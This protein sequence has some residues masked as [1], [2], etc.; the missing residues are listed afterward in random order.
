MEKKSEVNDEK[1]CPPDEAIWFDASSNPGSQKI[2]EE[3]TNDQTVKRPFLKKRSKTEGKDSRDE[4]VKNSESQEPASRHLKNPPR[5]KRQ[6]KRCPRSEL[7]NFEFEFHPKNRRPSEARKKP[8][9]RIPDEPLD[10]G[11][12]LSKDWMEV[13]YNFIHDDPDDDDF[14]SSAD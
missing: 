11:T 6:F 14:C 1:R 12:L 4:I 9:F 8:E 7:N 5:S 13:A 2:N 3:R 10:I